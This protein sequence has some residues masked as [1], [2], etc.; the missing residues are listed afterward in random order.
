MRDSEQPNYRP[1][2]GPVRHP[3]TS[4]S[5]PG[6]PAAGHVTEGT[7]HGGNGFT[8]VSRRDDMSCER[9]RLSVNGLLPTGR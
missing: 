5:T 7:R 6:I 9:G 2:Q 1:K 3:R 4:W 8:R